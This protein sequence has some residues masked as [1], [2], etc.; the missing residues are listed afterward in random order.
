MKDLDLERL[1]YPIGKFSEPEIISDDDIKRWIADIEQF[2]NRLNKITPYL[3]D[4]ELNY[5]Y[6]PEG[7][8]IQQVVHH[9]ADS[10]MNSFIRFKLCLTEELPTIKTYH[11]AKWAVLPDATGPDITSSLKLIEGLHAR[12]TKLLKS[13]DKSILSRQYIHPEK[14]QPMNLADTIALY[15]WHCNHHLA[16]IKQALADKRND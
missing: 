6:R 8:T 1:K 5:R 13:M 7:W 11:E 15:A 3:S 16:H 4:A 10:H 14:E 9:C 2:P 12:W